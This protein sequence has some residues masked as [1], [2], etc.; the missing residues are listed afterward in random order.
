VT[1]HLVSMVTIQHGLCA[2]PVSMD[3][4]A[5]LTSDMVCVVCV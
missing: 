3:S 5:G 2:C 4:S 1:S